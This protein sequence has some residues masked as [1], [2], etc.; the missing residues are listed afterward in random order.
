M[1]VTSI[2]SFGCRTSVFALSI[3][4]AAI[5][6]L[7]E[8]SVAQV[9]VISDFNESSGTWDGEAI[10]AGNVDFTVSDGQLQLSGQ[11]T[12]PTDPSSP[13]NTLADVWWDVDLSLEDGQSVEF[14]ADLISANQDDVFALIGTDAPNP[15]DG[16]IFL[17]DQDELILLKFGTTETNGV[18]P[19]GVSFL[20]WEEQEIKNENVVLSL[21]YTRLGDTL[22]ITAKV[23]DK[24]A[25]ESV[26]FEATVKDTPALDPTLPSPRGLVG[27]Q[28]VNGGLPWTTPIH[29]YVGFWHYT[30]G[31]Q[32][33][34]RVVFDNFTY[35]LRPSFSIERAVRLTVPASIEGIIVEWAPMFDGPWEPL[36]EEV[37]SRDGS[38]HLFLVAPESDQM[39]Y[40][41]VR[42]E[43]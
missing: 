13:G 8:H 16:Y 11:I 32:G 24:D 33:E 6:G 30:D 2:R 23:L 18:G 15:L 9:T 3:A 42:L 35:E 21:A 36:S 34:A 20:L 1:N 37:I 43:D 14:R 29:A 17:K 26:L 28:D 22:L 4:L 27:S 39:K 41:R 12:V 31:N 19:F 5:A 7:S 10:P 25:S 38:S 40:F